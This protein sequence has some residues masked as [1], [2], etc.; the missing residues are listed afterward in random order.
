MHGYINDML[1]R[2][3]S[4]RMK[5]LRS[6]QLSSIVVKDSPMVPWPVKSFDRNFYWLEVI[7]VCTYGVGSPNIAMRIRLRWAFFIDISLFVQAATRALKF[8]SSE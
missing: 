2:K 3:S 6:K 5:F 7:S 1:P 4:S 8:A